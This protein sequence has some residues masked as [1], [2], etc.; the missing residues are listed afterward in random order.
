LDAGRILMGTTTDDGSR[1][2]QV[3]GDIAANSGSDYV[4]LNAT[5]ATITIF[6]SGVEGITMSVA[7]GYVVFDKGFRCSGNS[8]VIG[9]TLIISPDTPA[10]QTAGISLFRSGYVDWNIRQETT[11]TLSITNGTL[12]MSLPSG[13]A[14]TVTGN[15]L[16]PESALKNLLSALA[17]I[18]FLIDG[19]TAT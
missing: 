8:N 7:G 10:S 12:T 1:R 11:G 14:A 2:L 19:T 6:K 13:A 5:A 15:R 18:G 16:N 9:Q 4:R 17:T 3:S